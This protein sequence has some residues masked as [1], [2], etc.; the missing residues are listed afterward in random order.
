M[1][2]FDDVSRY[3]ALKDLGK[4]YAIVLFSGSF[5]FVSYKFLQDLRS[6]RYS[7]LSIL[8]SIFGS[9]SDFTGSRLQNILTWV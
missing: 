1:K 5:I 9:A 2:G 7:A 6:I 8:N 4:H 3:I